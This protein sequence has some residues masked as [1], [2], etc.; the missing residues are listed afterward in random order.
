MTDSND[1]QA[2]AIYELAKKVFHLLKTNPG[3]FEVE[4]PGTRLRSMRRLKN[5][6][7]E[8]HSRGVIPDGAL[9][10]SSKNIGL[11]QSVSSTFR[12][13][14]KEGPSFTNGAAPIDSA[15]LLGKTLVFSELYTFISL[16]TS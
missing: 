15:F 12:R 7:K 8:N 11:G 6:A 2:R 1:L 3:N 16:I 4:F 14:S 13:S 9:D 5:E 10:D